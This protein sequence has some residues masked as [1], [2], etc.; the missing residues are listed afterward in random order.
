M[1]K[2]EEQ[3]SR[4]LKTP[5]DPKIFRAADF[6]EFLLNNFD[7]YL[8]IEIKKSTKG[9]RYNIPG[10][11]GI[12][13]TVYPK[14][15]RN[16]HSPNAWPFLP[17][18]HDEYGL[19]NNIYDR[20][21]TDNLS[22]IPQNNLNLG[23]LTQD[24]FSDSS[25]TKLQAI[26]SSSKETGNSQSKGKAKEEDFKLYNGFEFAVVS[27]IYSHSNTFLN[28]EDNEEEEEGVDEKEMNFENKSLQFVN[29]LVEEK[30]D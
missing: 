19:F 12:T 23:H 30:D 10:Q 16:R 18:K 20:E 1:T 8:D 3:L 11:T 22:E 2:L 28:N 29:F 17:S 9:T 27:P 15:Y 7:E 24:S 14:N 13:Y 6:K 4:I 5:F 21:I 26:Y 25:F